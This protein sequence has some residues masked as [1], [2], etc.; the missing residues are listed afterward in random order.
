MCCQPRG[1]NCALCLHPYQPETIPL[2]GPC[3][4][5]P[6]SYTQPGSSASATSFQYFLSP[7]MCTFFKRFIYLKSIVTKSR[8]ETGKTFHLLVDSPN[9][10]NDLGWAKTKLG[11][12]GVFQVSLVG[13]RTQGSKP[14]STVSPAALARSWIISGAPGT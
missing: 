7:E 6:L 12:M 8:G 5:L 1:Q 14:S 9:G 4:V 2:P 3:P 10:Q 13:A 11:A